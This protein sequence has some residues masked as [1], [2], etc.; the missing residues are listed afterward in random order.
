METE[1]SLSWSQGPAN[2]PYHEPDASSPHIPTLLRFILVLS[3]HLRLG[4]PNGLFSSGFPIKIVYKMRHL[5]LAF[6]MTRP[7]HTP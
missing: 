6:Y 7:S 1:G 2:G 3:S 5:S 4:L